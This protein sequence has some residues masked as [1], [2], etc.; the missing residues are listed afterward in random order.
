MNNKLKYLVFFSSC[1]N[2]FA[3]FLDLHIILVIKYNVG[4]LMNIKDLYINYIQYMA[5]CLIPFIQ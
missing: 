2:L 1:D 4:D 5:L 3:Y